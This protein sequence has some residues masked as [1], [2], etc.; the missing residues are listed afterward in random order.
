MLARRLVEAGV[1][2]IEVE[3]DQN[4]DT[5]NDQIK[6]M[7]LMTPS[8]DQTMA[9]LLGD[10]YQRGL[11]ANTLVVMATEFGRTPQ[12]NTVT[13]GRDHHPGVF[14]WWLAGGG[15]KGGYV[16]GQ[17]DAI[18]KHVA[19]NPVT[20]PDLNATVAMALGMDIGHIEHSPSGRPFTVADK[21][22]PVTALF[23]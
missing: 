21:G 14:T 2:F 13:A 8:V 16:H 5:H 23:A 9:A 7:R 1:R 20:M 17:S 15:V 18:G 4:W 12:I 19:E 3:D 10:L 22:R 6:S 11:L